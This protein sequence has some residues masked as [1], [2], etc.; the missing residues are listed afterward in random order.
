MVKSDNLISTI[1][2]RKKPEFRVSYHANIVP[3]LE[4]K[5]K[6]A[7]GENGSKIRK[8]LRGQNYGVKAISKLRCLND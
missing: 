4:I 2:P 3:Y 7:A 1:Y 8:I 5:V 6:S